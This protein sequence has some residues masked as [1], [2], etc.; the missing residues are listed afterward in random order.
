MTLKSTLCRIFKS[1]LVWSSGDWFVSQIRE[2]SGWLHSSGWI[3]GWLHSSGWILGWLHSSGW[4]LGWLHSS[5][6]ILGWLHSSGWI[7]GWLHSSGWI[8]GDSIFQDGFWVDSILQD[9]FWVVHAPLVCMVKFKFLAQFSVD[10]LPLLVVS[11]VW[12]GFMAHQPL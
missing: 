7:L 3:L 8:L 2:N 6:W 9:G 1:L 5:G 12:F 10:R 4:I 11:I